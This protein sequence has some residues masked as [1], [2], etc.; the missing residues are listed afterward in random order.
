LINDYKY[1]DEIDVDFGQAILFILTDVYPEVQ[2]ICK[3]EDQDCPPT[4][5]ALGI[6]FIFYDDSY[7]E[8][9]YYDY[10]VLE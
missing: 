8:S 4:A 5:I 3:C 9:Q 1:E 7:N 6:G 2:V 10:M